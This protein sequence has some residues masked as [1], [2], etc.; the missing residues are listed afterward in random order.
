MC[1]CKRKNTNIIWTREKHTK[2]KQKQ[3][4][5]AKKKKQSKKTIIRP[6]YSECNVCRFNLFYYIFIW[7][8]KGKNI[9]LVL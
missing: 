6:N 9:E 2:A 1:T 5:K 8:Y 7:L 3:A 4:K